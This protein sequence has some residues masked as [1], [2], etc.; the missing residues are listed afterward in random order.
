LRHRHAVVVQPGQFQ[1]QI[2]RLRGLGICQPQRVAERL[3]PLSNIRNQSRG[4]S[5]LVAK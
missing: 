1:I 4:W 5:P 3:V 2:V